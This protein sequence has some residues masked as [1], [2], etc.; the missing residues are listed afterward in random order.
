MAHSGSSMKLS[1]F[2]ATLQ[3]GAFEHEQVFHPG[4]GALGGQVADGV[5]FLLQRG[6]PAGPGHRGVDLAVGQQAHQFGAGGPVF[7]HQ[8]AL[9]LQGGPDGL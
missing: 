8:V 7:L 2:W 9:F 3:V 6:H 1:S 4:I 5:A